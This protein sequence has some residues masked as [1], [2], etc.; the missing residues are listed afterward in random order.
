MWS[1]TTSLPAGLARCQPCRRADPVRGTRAD[2]AQRYALDCAWC[3]AG[4]TAANRKR[5]Y[6]TSACSGKA[7][8]AT[9]LTR[10]ITDPHV[11]RARRDQAA[12]GLSIKR[13]AKLNHAWQK[14]GR[15]CAYCDQPSTTV[16]H[17]V[18][19]VRGGTNYEGNL[20]P[21]C[22][23][24]NSSKSGSLI[25]EWRTGKRLALHAAIQGG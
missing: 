13:R 14:Q 2:P 25:I 17:V 18:P 20:T 6:C 19:L 11:T 9:H 10:A 15:A 3:H 12:P 22:R 21:A 23:P 1:G 7:Y 4:F 8:S 16:D 24:C 5:T